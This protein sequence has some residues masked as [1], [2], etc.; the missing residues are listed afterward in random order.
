MLTTQIRSLMGLHKNW[1][2]L[3]CCRCIPSHFGILYSADCIGMTWNKQDNI[4]TSKYASNAFVPWLHCHGACPECLTH[5]P[6]GVIA[7]AFATPC[8]PTE[9]LTNRSRVQMGHRKKWQMSWCWGCKPS[10]FG[11]RCSVN[12]DGNDVKQTGLDVYTSNNICNDSWMKQTGLHIYTSNNICICNDSWMVDLQ[13]SP[14]LMFSY[15]PTLSL[16]NKE[17]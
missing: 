5:P 13:A 1:Q 9:D 14:L 16:I 7:V 8:H 3:S 15:I 17:T 11:N 12:C 2:M 6:L 4:N 10:H